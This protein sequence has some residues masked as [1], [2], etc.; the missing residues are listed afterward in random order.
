MKQLPA[1]VSSQQAVQWLLVPAQ[2]YPAEM[3][4]EAEL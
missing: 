2:R 4:L 1:E 3:L